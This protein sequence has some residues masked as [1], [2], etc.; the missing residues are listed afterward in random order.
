MPVVTIIA[1]LVGM[2][3]LAFTAIVIE[4]WWVIAIVGLV[5]I[6]ASGVLMVLLVRQLSAEERADA[7]GDSANP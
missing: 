1:F 3:V 7:E 2:T 6:T 5:H 4:T